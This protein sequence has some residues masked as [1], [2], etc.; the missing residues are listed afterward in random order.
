[1]SGY[2]QAAADLGLDHGRDA[3]A[4]AARF[5][6]WLDGT[7]RPWLVVLDDLHDAADL[8]ELWPAGS[9]GRVLITAVDAVAVPCEHGVLVRAVPAFSIR[10]YYV[11]CRER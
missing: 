1:M 6:A 11:T 3:E 9:A 10:G 7:S 8:G 5:T 2:A 4:V